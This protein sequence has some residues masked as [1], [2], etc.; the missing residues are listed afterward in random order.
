MLH[1]M[2]PHGR[3]ARDLLK[4]FLL[5]RGTSNNCGVAVRDRVG[6]HRK[7]MQAQG[8]RLVQVSVPDVRS[9]KFA[10]EARQQSRAVAASDRI[11]GDQVFVEAIS[12]EWDE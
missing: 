3:V 10:A 6:A 12:T 8:F 2:S 4:N 7:R 11:S 9:E 5:N 1:P